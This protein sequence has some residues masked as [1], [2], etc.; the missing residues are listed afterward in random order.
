MNGGQMEAF[1]RSQVEHWGGER[2]GP[3]VDCLD[4]RYIHLMGHGLLGAHLRKAGNV[5]FGICKQLSLERNMVKS[6]PLGV[7]D[8]ITI[9]RKFYK[10]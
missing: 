1:K 4:I 5:P 3:R 10:K 6:P 9:F 7:R 8:I 2:P